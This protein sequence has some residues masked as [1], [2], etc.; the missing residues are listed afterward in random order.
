MKKIIL[1]GGGGHAKS[2]IDVIESQKK[3]K[4]IGII[5]SNLNKNSKVSG[6]KILGKDND[7][8]KISAKYKVKLFHLSIGMIYNLE[9]RVVIFKK[10]K[11][12]GFEFPSIVSPQ[13][14]VSKN[15]FIGEGTIVMHNVIINS[16]VK[17]GSNCVINSGAILEHDSSIGHFT[18]VSTG[19]IVNGSVV[20]GKKCFIGSGSVIKESVKVSDNTFVK[21]TSKIKKNI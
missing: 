21:M 6:Y 2:C 17:I 9:K 5:D 13:S 20:I 19:C 12:M 16:N 3:Y 4:I 8:K 7:I 1:I 10:I 11:K 18:H 15:S 14:H